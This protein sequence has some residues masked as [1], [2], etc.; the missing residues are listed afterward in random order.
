L[1]P[2]DVERLRRE[3]CEGCRLASEL[4]PLG[5]KS[6]TFLHAKNDISCAE[7]ESFL[8]VLRRLARV[9]P[10]G[11]ETLSHAAWRTERARIAALLENGKL[12]VSRKSELVGCADESAWLPNIGQIRYAIAARGKSVFRIFSRRY[13][14]A[15]SDF[16][17]LCPGVL[18]KK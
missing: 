18:P 5:A 17:T 11:R 9:P 12:W 10:D 3:L 16:Q 4:R 8:K 7:V 15:L 14:Q 2:F 1:T 6:A 13:K